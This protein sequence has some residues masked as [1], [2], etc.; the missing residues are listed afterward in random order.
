MFNINFHDNK[1][2]MRALVSCALLSIAV[3]LMV[4]TVVGTAQRYENSIYMAYPPIFWVLLLLI[5]SCGVIILIFSLFGNQNLMTTSLGIIVIGAYYTILEGLRTLRGY[6]F[7]DPQDLNV[8]VSHIEEITSLGYISSTDFYPGMH[9]SAAILKMIT[10]IGFDQTALV[11]SVCYT[12]VYIIGVY[13][14]SSKV[15]CNKRIGILSTIFA[16]IPLF[17]YGYYFHPNIMGA[18]LIPLILYVVYNCVSLESPVKSGS[19]IILVIL[20]LII[21]FFH[22]MTT[23]FLTL[24]LIGQ[25]IFSAGL[26]KRFNNYFSCPEDQG[27]KKYMILIS[28]ILII[29]VLF[30]S[31]YLSF[32]KIRNQFAN[33]FHYILLEQGTST[34]DVHM[35][36][37]SQAGL[38]IYQLAELYLKMYGALTIFFFPIILFF[39]ISLVSLHFR[40]LRGIF[41]KDRVLLTYTML[42][43]MTVGL[44]IILYFTQVAEADIIR[45]LRVPIILGT[46]LDGII[47]YKLMKQLSPKIL[48][49]KMVTIL[50]IV[51]VI[52]AAILSTF[53]FYTSPWTSRS[54]YQVTSMELESVEWS[55][56][57]IS[58]DNSIYV[59]H[60]SAYHL[61][62]RY[63]Y[64]SEWSTKALFKGGNYIPDRYR[65]NQTITQGYILTGEKDLLFQYNF[66]EVLRDRLSRSYSRDDLW[67]LNGDSRWSCIYDSKECS[68]W[69]IP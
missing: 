48:R 44:S 55:L 28:V 65:F 57:Y 16:S 51:F 32:F 61:Q 59:T 24:I 35:G 66:P 36:L 67:V 23:I 3:L 47:I 11:L 4:A 34:F 68:I 25:V 26:S 60:L 6:P 42:L 39:F 29:V 12:L 8:H 62:K 20:A 30:Y 10:G 31:W 46:L 5:Y 40:S 9:V 50:V 63:F 64:T 69:T 53:N 7:A 56:N 41:W 58:K 19:K 14:F 15:T 13:I 37:I 54:N 52:V 18:L 33:F 1:S 38:E 17:G 2:L 43:F 45:V 21:T 22:P 49:A 27:N